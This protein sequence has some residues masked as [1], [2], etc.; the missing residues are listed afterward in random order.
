MWS[1][2]GW[3]ESTSA[4]TL[5]E[6]ELDAYRNRQRIELDPVDLVDVKLEIDPEIHAQTLPPSCNPGSEAMLRILAMRVEASDLSPQPFNELFLFSRFELDGK[7]AYYAIADIVGLHG[8]VLFGRETYGHPSKMGDV[9]IEIGE[10][11]SPDSRY[12]DGPGVFPVE[13][14]F[15]DVC[16]GSCRGGID[17]RRFERPALQ[18]QVCRCWRISSG[19]LGKSPIRDRAGSPVG[20]S[21]SS[22]QILP[23]KGRSA[24]PILGSNFSLAKSAN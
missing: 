12:T 21:R 18:L 16:I 19:N 10:N 2:K 11:R 3:P 7:P 24:G 15:V 6:E 13:D 5:T 14:G 8:D 23:A 20:Q 17:R 4:I 9:D 22:F 1:P